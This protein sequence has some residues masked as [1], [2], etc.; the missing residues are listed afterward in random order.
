MSYRYEK[1]TTAVVNLVYYGRMVDLKKFKK[2][3]KELPTKIEQEGF[4]IQPERTPAAKREHEPVKER[5][6]ENEFESATP[7]VDTQELSVS[8]AQKQTQQKAAPVVVPKD[9]LTKEIEKILEADLEDM[10]FE[11]PPETQLKFK[12]EGEETSNR[13][14]QMMKSGVVKIKKVLSMIIDW[15]HI[16]PGVNRFFIEKQAKIKAEKILN[17]RDR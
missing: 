2:E 3:S 12:L 16:I 8:P 10:Y 11:M 17:L 5:I 14:R 9:A 15:L 6:P 1:Y 4:A 13:I 7:D